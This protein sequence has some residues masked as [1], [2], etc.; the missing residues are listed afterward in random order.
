MLKI[1]VVEDNEVDQKEIKSVVNVE[2]F[3]LSKTYSIETFTSY[4]QKLKGIIEDK[5]Y[6]KIYILDIELKTKISGIEIAKKIRNDDWESHI[7]FISSHDQQFYKIYTSIYEIFACIEKFDNMSQ[8]L[9]VCLKEI[10]DH[11]MDNGMFKYNNRN[12]DLSIKYNSILYITRDKEERKIVVHT[13]NNNFFIGLTFQEVI[14]KLDNRFKTVHRC[15]IANTK[16]VEKYDWP[17][18]TFVLDTGEKVDLLSR[19]YRKNVK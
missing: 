12:C 6:K 3:S 9:S 15:C 1:I 8:R 7:I 2:L 16:R 5:S 19:M 10:I 14:K 13:D 17:K 4:S 18:K 11:D